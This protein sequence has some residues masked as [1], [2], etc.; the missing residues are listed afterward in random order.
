M[1]RSASKA[2]A[3][4]P[5]IKQH[6]AKGA[7]KRRKHAKFTIQYFRQG[8]HTKPLTFELSSLQQARKL[9]RI[10]SE[11]KGASVQSVTITS[12]DGRTERWLYLKG[13]WRQKRR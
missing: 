8:K 4:P 3:S 5:P 11:I 1:G 6:L 10:A 9:A 2:G 7:R 12:E 13:T